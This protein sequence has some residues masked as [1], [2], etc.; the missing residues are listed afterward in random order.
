MNILAISGSTR[1]QSTNTA[2]LNE[3]AKIAGPKHKVTVFSGI[4]EL[5]VFSPDDEAA[6]LPPTVQDFVDTIRTSDALVIASPEY[7]HAIPGGLKNA[8][9]WLV[10]RDE[11]I[12]KPIALLHASHR[13]EDMLKSLRLV[14]STISQK[15]A[16]EVFLRLP[17]MHLSPSEIKEHL[18]RAK[19]RTD[20]ENFLQ[21]LEGIL[22]E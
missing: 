22:E 19:T 6:P 12:C 2:F 15:F 5:P 11:M 4:R 7:V 8:I 20:V 16:P 17:L 13:G 10:S 9:D 14:L 21:K 1:A 18:T 3:V